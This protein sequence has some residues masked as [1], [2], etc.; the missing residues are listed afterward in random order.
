M[1]FFFELAL[2]LLIMVTLALGE[3]V[4]RALALAVWAACTLG[5][6]AAYLLA[7]RTP[8]SRDPLEVRWWRALRYHWRRANG[9]LLAGLAAVAAWYWLAG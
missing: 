1:L 8:A 2:F 3:F 7:A 5:S 6:V 9:L 4:S